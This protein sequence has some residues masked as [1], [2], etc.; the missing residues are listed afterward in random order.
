M[1]DNTMLVNYII[2]SKAEEYIKRNPK[3]FNKQEK[4]KFQIQLHSYLTNPD[5]MSVD[6]EIYDFLTYYHLVKNKTRDQE[7]GEYLQNKYGKSVRKV[8]DIGAGR[9]CHL[10]SRL[11]NFGWQ[12]TAVDPKIRLEQKEIKNCHI[13]QIITKPFICDEYAKNNQG[14]KVDQFDLLIGLEPCDATEHIIRQAL[15]YDKPFDILLCYQNHNALNGTHFK[16]PEMW[17]DHLLSI[18]EEIDITKHSSGYIATNNPI[19]EK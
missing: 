16:T 4:D 18:S 15:A 19:A 9:M 7:F 12:M 10:S 3:R 5:K 13:K 17:Y 8:I 6:D 1:D 14:T 2:R 11:G